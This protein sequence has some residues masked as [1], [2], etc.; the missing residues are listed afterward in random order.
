MSHCVLCLLQAFLLVL[1]YLFFEFL[2]PPWQYG[3]SIT[4]T[5]GW[6]AP[7]GTSSLVL[8][9]KIPSQHQPSMVSLSDNLMTLLNS[10]AKIEYRSLFTKADTGK[11]QPYL[12]M[13]KKIEI[14]T[15]RGH[16]QRVDQNIHA[17]VQI[18]PHPVLDEQRSH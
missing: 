2:S 11:A 18:P 9:A 8:S 1:L 7:W 14:A 4:L 13:H 15:C 12:K 10:V 3:P 6:G 17:K 5:R 16:V